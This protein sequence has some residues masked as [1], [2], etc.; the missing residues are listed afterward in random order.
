MRGLEG[1]NFEKENAM[2][3]FVVSRGIFECSSNLD[4]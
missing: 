4:D 2:R 1:M 3:R